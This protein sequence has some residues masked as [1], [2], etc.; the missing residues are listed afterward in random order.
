M[1]SGTS[2]GKSQVGTAQVLDFDGGAL[3][4][5]NPRRCVAAI[6]GQPEVLAFQNVSCLLVIEGFDVPLDEGEIFAV[7]VGV[8]TGALLAGPGRD[9]IGS[10]QAPVSVQPGGDLGVAFQALERRLAAEFVA[11]AAV[12]VSVQK[13]VRAGQRSGGNL[14]ARAEAKQQQQRKQNGVAKFGE[15]TQAKGKRAGRAENLPRRMLISFP[16]PYRC[17]TLHARPSTGN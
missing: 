8:T 13:L 17:V 1:T 14:R 7:V 2:R 5:E 4:R 15:I 16:Y 9:V 10:V 3:L 11:T 12:G 6:A